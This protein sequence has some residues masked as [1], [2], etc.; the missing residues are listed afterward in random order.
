MFLE[1]FWRHGFAKEYNILQDEFESIIPK[2]MQFISG[3][4]FTLTQG[5]L[6]EK[7]VT[8]RQCI[9]KIYINRPDGQIKMLVRKVPLKIYA[10]PRCGIKQ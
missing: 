3:L 5:L 7:L 8:L 9:E 4:K 2:T 6:Q 1:T 10:L